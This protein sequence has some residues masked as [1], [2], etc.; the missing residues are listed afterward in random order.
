MFTYADETGNSGRNIFDQN[1]HFRLGAILATTD[2]APAVHEAIVPFLKQNGVER[3]HA[4]EWPEKEVAELGHKT[5]DAIEKCGPWSFNLTEIHKPYMAPT[6]FVDVIFDAG[7]NKEVPGDWYWD[8]L[9]RHVLCLTI[10]RA[11][12]LQAAKEFWVSY[13]TDNIAGILQS[14]ELIDKAIKAADIAPQV[15]EVIIAAFKFARSH[16]DAFTLNHT[17]KRKG[18]QASSPNVVAFTQLFQAIHEFAAQHKCSPQKLVHDRQDEFRAA[19]AESYKY[20]GSVIWQDSKDGRFPSAKLAEYD[21]AS[22]EMPSSNDNAGLQATDILL[23]ASQR[24]PKSKELGL[25][26]FRMRENT[27]DFFL[28]RRMSELIVHMH[29]LRKERERIRGASGPDEQPW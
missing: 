12:S 17:S 13:L 26:K 4:H 24:K 19:L 18:Y 6:K 14:L 23:W 16:P 28:S 9:N 20:F 3:V 5:L 21:L 11:M 27:T 2:I 1:E 8:E 15:R 10:D 29:L 22:F 7:E 25:L